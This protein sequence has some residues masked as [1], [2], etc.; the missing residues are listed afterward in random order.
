MEQH[1]TQYQRLKMVRDWYK[2]NH[3]AC[4]ANESAVMRRLGIANGF[5]NTGDRHGY[6]TLRESTI[7]KI[8]NAENDVNVDWLR[9]GTGEMFCHPET[10]AQIISEGKPPTPYYNI[11]FL[12][13]ND[14]RTPV[15]EGQREYDIDYKPLNRQG[16]FWCN[17]TG[18]SMA[19]T[20]NGGDKLCLTPV[21][22]I[23]KLIF[24]AIY[25]I[26]TRYR[27]H[28]IRRVIGSDNEDCIR[29]VADNKEPCY[30]GFQDIPK[31]DVLYIYKVVG[32]IRTF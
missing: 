21:N 4:I 17:V 24:G 20:I 18:T 2:A 32:A 29:L 31:S 26:I 28:T 10:A 5:F 25:A 23:D 8:K 9:T 22:N 11:D 12:T 7:T 6:K 27:M 16:N 15:L 13:D 1:T 3:P 19:P 14:W 30:A